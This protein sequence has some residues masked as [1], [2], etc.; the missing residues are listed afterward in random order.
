MTFHSQYSTLIISQ[1]QTLLAELFQQR[2]D[3]VVLKL[4]D[5]LL[6]LVHETTDGGQQVVP[7]LE[8]EGHGYCPKT[9]SLQSWRMKVIG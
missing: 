3:L 7:R 8:K 6:T 4:D 5:L 1:Q 9:A 2:F